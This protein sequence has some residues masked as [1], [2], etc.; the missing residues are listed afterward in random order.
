MSFAFT[1]KGCRNYNYLYVI[2]PQKVLD[3]ADDQSVVAE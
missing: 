3:I 2:Q 1:L